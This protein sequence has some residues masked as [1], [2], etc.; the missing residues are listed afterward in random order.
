M[1]PI[2]WLIFLQDFFENRIKKSADDKKAQHAKN[3]FMIS[4]YIIKG[5]KQPYNKYVLSERAL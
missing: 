5:D 3:W 1:D 4:V 2:L